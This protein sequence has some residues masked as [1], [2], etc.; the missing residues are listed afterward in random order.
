MR[1][2][3]TGAAMGVFRHVTDRRDGLPVLVLLVAG[4]V[5][6]GGQASQWGLTDQAG[7][8]AH[9]APA[10]QSGQGAHWALAG[11]TGRASPRAVTAAGLSTIAVAGMTSTAGTGTT[12]TVTATATA[13]AEPTFAD[14]V[15]GLK[16]DVAKAWP[17]TGT[18][19]PGADFSTLVLLVSDGRQAAAITA[20]GVTPTSVAEME[21]RG[22]AVPE[23]IAPAEWD[24]RYAVAIN[25]ALGRLHF[26]PGPAG[27]RIGSV[28]TV[29]GKTTHEAFRFYVQGF[30]LG[31]DRIWPSLRAEGRRATEYPL[32]ATPRLYRAMIYNELREAYRVPDTRPARLAAAAY[33]AERWAREF[34]AERERIAVVDI[35][36]GTA[37]YVGKSAVAMAAATPPGDR[38][39]QR[40]FLLDELMKPAT[41]GTDSV[42]LE[43]YPIGLAAGLVADD[44]GLDWKAAVV[45]GPDTPLDLVV[46]GV[47]PSAR[48]EPAGLRRT[49]DEQV[50]RA[51]TEIAMD[52]DPAIA[53]FRD[54]R[55]ALLLVPP[56]PEGTQPE[57]RSLSGEYIVDRVPGTVYRRFTQKLRVSSGVLEAK[58]LSVFSDQVDGVDYTIIPFDPTGG[59]SPL[60][61]DR[62]RFTSANLTGDLQVRAGPMLAG[63]KTFVAQ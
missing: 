17:R 1:G 20:E 8:G 30:A 33:W 26:E 40:A 19:F 51:N 6:G 41:G 50:A 61:G 59:D 11:Q 31:P 37:E 29:F 12:A 21:R 32:R 60:S 28:L 15:A 47:T 35:D 7:R 23:L 9:W 58:E 5:T 42:D 45:N 13:T 39:E 24:G 18:L 57:P 62:V 43:S 27:Q 63:K 38:R 46:R 22:V 10:G 36:A 25:T 52:L 53:A 49:I 56:P 48:P 14:Y 2:L 3:E 44:L 16:A 34:P 54:P 4:L 55:T